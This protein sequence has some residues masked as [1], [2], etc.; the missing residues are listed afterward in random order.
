MCLNTLKP[1]YFFNNNSWIQRDIM[2]AIRNKIII[3]TGSAPNLKNNTERGKHEKYNI[4]KDILNH[5]NLPTA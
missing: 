2:S 1:E 4:K 5:F 3:I